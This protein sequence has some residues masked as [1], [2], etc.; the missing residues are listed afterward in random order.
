MRIVQSFKAEYNSTQQNFLQS[1]C[2]TLSYIYAK[3]IGI[4]ITLYTDTKG[5]D[6]LNHIPFKE[7]KIELDNVDR[8][9][10][11][12][13][14]YPKIYVLEKEPLGILH[15][16]GD[17]FLKKESI[18]QLLDF[19]DY[20]CIVQ[21]Y[22][23]KTKFGF[24]Y[25][26]SIAEFKYVDLPLWASKQCEC[27]YNTG[28]LGFNNQELKDEFIQAYKDTAKKYHNNK[29][30]VRN[31]CPDIIIEQKFLLDL[32]NYKNLKVKTLLDYDKFNEQA[33]EI[34]YTH[35]L[36]SAKIHRFQE[37]INKIYE[38]DKDI[39]NKL[40]SKWINKYKFMWI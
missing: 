14:A 8:F 38:L 36:G 16:D 23:D 37:I 22:E 9:D 3:S 31:S 25:D 6:I 26:E 39:Y 12:L 2:F 28:I 13:Y 33:K 4:D 15:I 19:K 29:I 40:K 34:G 24:G 7:V 35:V 21:C 18:K 20:D 5:Y 11:D 32:T 1:V 30:K 27:M 17:V 10:E